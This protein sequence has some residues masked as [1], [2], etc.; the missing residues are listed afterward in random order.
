[1]IR[2][3]SFVITALQSWSRHEAS[4]AQSLAVEISKD[5]LVLYVNPP[6]DMTA[7]LENNTPHT[8]HSNRVL[9]GCDKA[10]RRINS[11]LWVLEPPIIISSINKVSSS[12]VFDIL[13]RRNNRKYADIIKWAMEIVGIKDC[14]HINDNDLFRSFYMNELLNP[15]LSIFYRRSNL[16]SLST[17]NRH[18]QRIETELA[19]KSDVIITPNDILAEEVR[20]YNY[21][22]FNIG[23]GVDLSGYSTD[24][25]YKRPHDLNKI[26]SPIIGFTG[27]LGVPTVSPNLI[28]YIAQR[29][30]FA[31]IVLVGGEDRVFQRHAL[32]RL[33]NV[34]F[35]GE[36]S[37]RELP[38]YI[39]S[40]DICINPEPINELTNSIYPRRITQ[41]LALGK[42]VV[43]TAT[44]TMFAFNSQV[45]LAADPEHFA[46]LISAVFSQPHIAA[47]QLQREEFARAMTW[48]SCTQR[49]YAVIEMIDDELH[50]DFTP[51]SNEKEL[52]YS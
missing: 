31:S 41:Y 28:Y 46:D 3:N 37:E 14:F 47:Q 39:N 43:A 10:L 5:N 23:Q 2:N 35:L 7:L 44:D 17:W 9:R 26:T 34:H 19:R 51:L 6:L 4:N 48:E 21:N 42:S 16:T 38:Q 15:E 8:E 1:M 22:T 45:L 50:D 52:I 32:H 12:S 36:K 30:P 13:N 27:T 24:I 18:G 25:Q 40:F 20:G 29:F 11:N 49:L 33:A